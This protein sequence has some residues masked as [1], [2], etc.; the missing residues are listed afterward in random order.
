MDFDTP[1]MTW[2]PLPPQRPAMI[3]IFDLQNRPG[4]QWGLVVIPC[5]FHRDCSSRSWDMLVTRSVWTNAWT[6]K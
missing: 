2:M 3:L 1:A 6:N 4:H 5:K